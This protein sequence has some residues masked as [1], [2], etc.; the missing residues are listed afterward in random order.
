[1]INNMDYIQAAALVKIEEKKMLNKAKINRMIESNTA[2]DILKI[3]SETDY[4][5]SMVGVT[6]EEDYENILSNELKRVYS[7]A[8][9][10]VKSNKEVL[11]VFKLK[12]DFQN[13]KQQLKYEV[14]NGNVEEIDEK[15]RKDYQQALS[16]Y[17][18]S[19]DIQIAVIILDKLYFKRLKTLCKKINLDILNKY[20]DIVL[21]SYNLLTFIRLKNQK[22][23]YK[24]ASFCLIDSEELLNIYE[25]DANYISS[26]E[27]FYDDKNLWNK[28]SKTSKI[29]TIEKELENKV[30]SL[31]KEYKNVNY[32]IETIIAYII[33]KEYEIKAI[34]LIMTAKINKIP[35]E[36]IKERM[37]DIYV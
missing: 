7:Y 13:L 31:I 12:Y 32:G 34:R 30:I 17:E 24:Y 1:M 35:V 10:L 37:R 25:N 2:L 20:C 33:A 8:D 36:I 19:N 6:K 27:K 23:S 21:K 16:E 11:E 26:L 9:E 18:K 29:S 22:R 28:F 5:K 15:Y 3:L 4:S 14:K